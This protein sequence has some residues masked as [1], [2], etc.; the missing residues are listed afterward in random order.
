MAHPHRASMGSANTN[1]MPADGTRHLDD[2]VAEANRR[3]EDMLPSPIAHVV[4]AATS[5]TT[6]ASNLASFRRRDQAFLEYLLAMNLATDIIQR[7]RDWSSFSHSQ[8][9]HSALWRM[10]WQTLNR[11]KS[12]EDQFDKIKQIIRLEN[13]RNG[14]VAANADLNGGDGP[15]NGEK[16]RP[17][18][19]Q[20]VRGAAS[21]PVSR[22][23]GRGD[24]M[25]LDPPPP[26][27][28]NEENTRQRPSSSDFSD[29]TNSLDSNSTTSLAKA[30]PTVRPKPEALHGRTLPPSLAAGTAVNGASTGTG[31]SDL[32]ARFARLRPMSVPVPP[33]SDPSPHDSIPQPQ[34]QYAGIG[35]ATMSSSSTTSRPHGPR[36]L[37]ALPPKLPLDTAVAMNMPK[38]PESAYSP[39][40][41]MQI[42]AGVPLP[43]TTAR[44]TIRSVSS[45]SA[46]APGDYE[47]GSYFP[48]NS[49]GSVDGRNKRKG[50]IGLPEEGRGIEAKILFDYMNL[51][52][53]LLID[54][55]DRRAFDEGHIDSMG[56]IC[57]S[58]ESLRREMTDEELERATLLSPDGEMSAFARRDQAD[59]VVYYDQDTATP[60]F[61]QKAQG[62][63]T[64]REDSLRYV[65][66]ALWEL[67]V[68]KQ[69]KRPPLMLLGG[70]DAWS[71]LL[72][73]AS[74]RTSNTLDMMG[75]KSKAPTRRPV[76]APSPAAMLA[77]EKRRGSRRREYNPLD[78]E[79]ER[80]WLE[81]ARK[82]SVYIPTPTEEEASQGLDGEEEGEGEGAFY[83]TQED[84]LRRFPAVSPIQES[85]SEAPARSPREVQ[86]YP[87]QPP[88]SNR[89]PPPPQ[90]QA[91]PPQPPPH[92]NT[93]QYHPNSYAT[94]NSIPHPSHTDMPSRPP[95]AAPRVSY[96]GAHDRHPITNGTYP[97]TR[98]TNDQQLRPYIAPSEMPHNIRLPRTGLIN[99]GVTCYMNAVLQCLSAT[100]PLST[101][102]RQDSY[103][104][105]LQRENW[106]GARGLFPQH[107]G[108]LIKHLWLGDV[109]AVRPSTFR[110]FCARLDSKYGVDQ[111][112][113]AKEFLEFALD[114]LHEDLN[115]NWRADPP[116]VLTKEEEMMRERLPR[117]YASLIE[118]SR[119]TKRSRSLVQ[120]LFAGQHASRIRCLKCGHTSTTYETF[121]SISVEIPRSGSG[122]IYSCLNSYC[123]EEVLSGSESPKCEKC[124]KQRE[125]TKQITLT[126]APRYLVVHF[127]RFTAKLAK[128]HTPVSFPLRGLQLDNYVLPPMTQKER[129]EVAREIGDPRFIDRR[130]EESM[131]GPFNYDAYGVVRHL[132]G[133]LS[134]GHYIAM[135][136]D[137]G[138]NVWRQFND[139]HTGD[140]EPGNDCGKIG[141]RE[142]YVVFFERVGMGGESRF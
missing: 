72:G 58:P 50:S 85:M 129:Q 117:G 32:A 94:A 64:A 89:P 76:P 2:L 63:R 86:Q 99:F 119:F 110:S 123:K 68:A 16:S 17:T 96:S 42:P 27:A 101:A 141:G 92:A 73:T 10:Y 53:M 105:H 28:A 97:P 45:A 23:T 67:N 21:R 112:Q 75:V 15:G 120:D 66:D 102:F 91:L 80:R 133:S 106:K 36:D 37:P 9:K 128:I 127:K 107:F 55:R 77:M 44:S 7:H 88:P 54:V 13:G 138:R 41:N 93:P 118:W 71:D 113:D 134:S 111:Q 62:M 33:T 116:H 125:H 136:K 59:L 126:R 11:L 87:V 14:V 70:L 25:F 29:F 34:K 19:V 49:S 4:N 74:L 52:K 60:A 140:I 114:Y 81:S 100:L 137:P 84:F 35:A 6:H 57:L 69:L 5:S 3:A 38:P 61:L 18:S 78:A 98:R 47:N 135:C 43:R 90:S 103:A 109:S 82:E 26:G 79:E 131:T 139:T 124:Q 1:S 56:T 20:S 108:N 104:P 51:Y 39:A 12:M 24:E 40:R 115:V 121:F 8:N 122:D 83:R 130:P 65:F 22:A 132:G 142:A 46:K 48:R 95:P 30:K 31:T